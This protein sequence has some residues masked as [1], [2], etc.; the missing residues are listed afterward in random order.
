MDYVDL[1]QV[2]WPDPNVPLEETFTTLDEIKKSGKVRHIGVTN[3]NISLIEQAKQY[4]EIVSNQVLYN[5]IA[6]FD[7]YPA[8]LNHR[9]GR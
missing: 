9:S 4:T 8:D 3:F 6:E 7:D 2:H 5:M 1:Y